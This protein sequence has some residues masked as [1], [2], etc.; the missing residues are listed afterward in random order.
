MFVKS[1]KKIGF[2]DFADLFEKTRK[3]KDKANIHTRNWK[4][5]GGRKKTLRKATLIFSI[6]QY[7]FLMNLL[8]VERTSKNQ[9]SNIPNFGGWNFE[10][11]RTY[12]YRTSRTS[13][14][15][16]LSANFINK[17]WAKNFPNSSKPNFEHARTSDSGP[18][19]NFEPPRHH[20]KPNSSQKLNCL[21]HL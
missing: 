4:F 19:P 10:H 21:F 11:I 1:F 7:L 8:E 20:Q 5:Y 18:K 2:F 16:E 6:V 14:K 13:P 9:T 15:T 3:S 12:S 17:K